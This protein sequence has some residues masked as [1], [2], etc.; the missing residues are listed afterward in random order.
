MIGTEGTYQDT[1]TYEGYLSSLRSLIVRDFLEA[2]KGTLDYEP[3]ELG[4]LDS[5]E[6]LCKKEGGGSLERILG[7]IIGNDI[8]KIDCDNYETILDDGLWEKSDL[9]QEVMAFATIKAHSIIESTPPEDIYYSQH[10][11]L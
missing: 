10:Q 5:L 6:I 2:A 9:K 1:Y 7:D 11:E 4:F 8:L 3:T